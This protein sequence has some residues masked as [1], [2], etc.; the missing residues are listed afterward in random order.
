M[1][2]N[3]EK[4]LISFLLSSLNTKIDCLGYPTLNGLFT[5]NAA[6]L[7]SCPIVAGRGPLKLLPVISL[8]W[9]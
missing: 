3:P 9:S 2:S 8:Q 5:Y 4:T 7:V 1:Q 6:R